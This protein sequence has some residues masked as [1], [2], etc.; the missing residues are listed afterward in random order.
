MT[1]ATQTPPSGPAA[2]PAPAIKVIGVGGAGLHAVAHMTEAGLA[3][4]SF[5]GVHTDARALGHSQLPETLLLG[6]ELTRG[7][8]A[9]GDPDIGRAAAEAGAE[10][11]RGLCAGADLVVVVAGLGGG[12]GSGSAPVV[13]QAVRSNRALVLSLVALPFDFEGAR[14]QQQAAL[15][16]RQLKTASDAVICLSNQKVAG[17]IDEKTKFFDALRFSNEMLTQGLRGIWRLVTCTG[18]IN[19]DFADLCRVVRG[20]QAESCFATA[21]AA[22]ENRAREVVAQLMAHPLLDQGRLLGEADAVLVSLAGGADLTLK[23]VSQVMEQLN[24]ACE[25]A[26][27]IMGAAVEAAFQDR[28]AVTLVVTKRNAAPTQGNV[29][30]DLDRP[31]PEPPAAEF[32]TS[33][34]DLETQHLSR[35]DVARTPSRFVPPAPSLSPEKVEAL[36]LKQGNGSARQRKQVARM[37]QGMLPLEVIPKGRFAKSEPTLHHGEDLDT[38][39]YIRRGV[40]LN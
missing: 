33:A 12:T 9:G 35:G 36:L 39:T 11:L 5:A 19:V 40:A 24:R 15:A 28:L 16:L 20:R 25:G 18:L 6:G 10:K 31:E 37:R 30:P 22:G 27:V 34:L 3:G 26:Q 14:R 13:A 8:G 21:E 23:E 2:R 4:V 29:A 38:P 1:Q 32:P 7:L 17:L